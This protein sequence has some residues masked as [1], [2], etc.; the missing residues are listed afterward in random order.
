MK[1]SFVQIAGIL[2]LL[3]GCGSRPETSASDGDSDESAATLD[4]NAT[5]QRA[6]G[7][8]GP[9]R[10]VAPMPTPRAN[11]CSVAIGKWLLVIG[12]NHRTDTGFESLDEVHAAH[13][14]PDGTLGDWVLAGH[15]PS[16]VFEC[17]VANRGKTLYLI[18]GLYDDATK[19]AQVWAADFSTGSGRLSRFTSLGPLPPN[20]RI[21]Y[22]AAFARGSS[23]YA[24]QAQLPQDGD[25]IATWQVDISKGLLG[26]WHETD[27]VSGFRGHP[28]Y[29]QS[30]SYIFTLGGYAGGNN[31]V[32]ADVYGVEIQENGS[33]GKGFAT[34]PM[35]TPTAF[36]TV[37]AVDNYL[38][39]VGGKPQIFTAGTPAVASVR[40]GTAGQLD[41]WKPQTPLPQGRT[42]HT[43]LVSGNYLYVLGGGFDGPGLDSVYSAQI[44]F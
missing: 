1:T 14:N 37:V 5:A 27:W 24:M 41:A 32:V 8:V 34:S 19:G 11:H 22:S 26:Q 33:L 6:N 36:G 18:D 38:F 44:R 39:S 23:L 29:A 12:G 15:T 7:T 42:N 25:R 31:D 43:T 40:V 4:D 30:G 21:L 3:L 9:W 17:V 28:Q 35:L 13:V 10:T 2:V 20:V 16:P